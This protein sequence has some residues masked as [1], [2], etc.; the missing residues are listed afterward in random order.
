MN[1]IVIALGLMVLVG[2]A[3][4]TG[5]LLAG[6]RH[7]RARVRLDSQRW[8]LWRWEQELISAADC[9]GCPSCELLRRRAEL[10]RS[11]LDET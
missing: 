11:P 10:Q 2:L 6:E 1:G 3:A 7:H 5:V 8:V 9:R 4:G